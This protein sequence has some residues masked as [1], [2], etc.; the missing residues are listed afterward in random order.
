M[1]IIA[2]MVSVTAVY[3]QKS[4][5]A[6]KK[7][8]ANTKAACENPKKAGNPATWI[9]YAKANMEAY[10]AVQGNGW[11]GG[12][13]SEL[14]L[15]MA[16]T[17]PTETVTETVSGAE[18][19]VDVYPNCKYYFNAAGVLQMIAVTKPYVENALVNA[20]EAYAKA[21]ECDVKGAKTK[22][23]ND[24]LTKIAEHFQNEAMNAYQFG[25]L[26]LSSALFGESAATSAT[27][28]LNKID[29]ATLYNCGL[30]AFLANDYA[31]AK[32]MMKT[33]IGMGYYENGEAYAKLAEC[34][35]ALGDTLA[36]KKVLEEGFAKCTDNQGII[37][38][39]INLYL[40]SNDDPEKLF[41]LLDVAKKNEPNNASLYYVEGNIRKQL[42]Q[43]EAAVAA[44]E[45]CA[46][47]NPGYEFGYIGA[48]LLHWDEAVKIQEEAENEFNDKKYQALVD[49]FDATLE[50]AIPYF[51]KAFEITQDTGVKISLGEYL[52]NIFFRFRDKG[53]SYQANYEKYNEFVKANSAE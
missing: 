48:G 22:D 37:V 24:G 52:K 13:R 2:M 20:R 32:E 36:C 51:E 12:S 40:D 11:I 28:P 33:C 43:T 42:G 6:I 16:G 35:K 46:E 19:T 29:S 27:K 44:Y 8:V 23:I 5:E 49:K 4:E 3:A 45:K 7:A 47:V 38:G 39:L 50:A 10:N 41:A 18:Y 15:I 1:L 26:K 9:S 21:A 25:D 34:E 30:T 53:E 31:K 17:K 14:Q